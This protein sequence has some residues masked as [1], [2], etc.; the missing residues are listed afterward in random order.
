MRRRAAMSAMHIGRP[1]RDVQV[2][3]KGSQDHGFAKVSPRHGTSMCLWS[4]DTLTG[5]Y[6]VSSITCNRHWINT[7]LFLLVCFL[8]AM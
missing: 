2:R 1:A 5:E 6:A 7:P 8:V 3:E 4:M